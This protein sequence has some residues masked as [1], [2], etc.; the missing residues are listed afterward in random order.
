MHVISSILR[1]NNDTDL[2]F[3]CPGCNRAHGIR[4]GNVD[5]G[6]KWEWDGNITKPTI[7]PSIL[8]RWSY[9]D[10]PVNHICHSYIN[11]GM[12]IFLDDCTHTSVNSTVE[13]PDWPL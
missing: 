4:H 9:G 12:I 6:P 11:D 7:T 2:L 13:L 3:W 8:V 1:C 10:P 5:D